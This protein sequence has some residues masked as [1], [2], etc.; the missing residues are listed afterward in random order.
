MLLLPRPRLPARRLSTAAVPRHWNWNSEGRGD[1]HT[2]DKRPLPPGVGAADLDPAALKKDIQ[3]YGA[4]R[5][6]WDDIRATAIEQH[7]GQSWRT[8]D[9]QEFGVD[10]YLRR[11][12]LSH[13]SLACGLSVCVGGKLGAAGWANQ[14]T[15]MG[16]EPIDGILDF[17]KIL[18]SAFKA[19]PDIVDA[20]AHDIQRFKTVDPATTS[21]LGVYLFYKGVQALCCA[22]VANHFYTQRGDAGQLIAFLLQSEMSA[23]FGVDIH[24]GCRLGRGITIDHATGVVLGETAV[25]G[26]NVYLMHDVTLGAT[27][28]S[29]S[30]QRHPQI[31]S[32]VFLGAKSTILGNIVVGEGATVAAAALVTKDVPAGHTAVGMPAKMRPPKPGANELG[33]D[34]RQFTKLDVTKAK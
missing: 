11:H 34:L 2:A 3:S 1:L 27:G 5:E 22:R 18:L 24:P 21:L 17:R 6:V 28:T 7:R 9:L 15:Q 30:H 29:D 16:D 13:A 25:I 14:T 32:N 31:E 23:A 26:D 20:V 8:D 4:A 10:G 12:I 19:D 33:T